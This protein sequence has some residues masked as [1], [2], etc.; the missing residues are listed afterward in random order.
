MDAKPGRREA[1]TYGN[2][3]A[4]EGKTGRGGRRRQDR[5]SLEKQRAAE[6]QAAA[7]QNDDDDDLY[8]F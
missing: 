1:K 4:Y 5:F 3:N 2:G 6:Q 7:Q 8:D